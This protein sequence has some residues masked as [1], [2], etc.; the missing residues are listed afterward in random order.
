MECVNCTCILVF[1]RRQDLDN[2]GVHCRGW[3]DHSD[4]SHYYSLLP[5]QVRLTTLLLHVFEYSYVII[6][7]LMMT[8][9]GLCPYAFCKFYETHVFISS[10]DMHFLEIIH[11]SFTI[12]LGKIR[13]KIVCDMQVNCIGMA[14]WW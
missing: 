8:Q 14:R 9:S 2:C 1:D 7:I 4:C 3:S 12:C 10:S 13:R 11:E 6:H 5:L